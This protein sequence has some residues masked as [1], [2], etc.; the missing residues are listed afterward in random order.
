VENTEENRRK[1]RQLLFTSE[2]I[3]NC[4]SGVILFDET[5]HKNQIRVKDL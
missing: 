2:G 3:E 1:Y 4:I 5:F